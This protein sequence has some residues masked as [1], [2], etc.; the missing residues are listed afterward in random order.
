MKAEADRLTSEGQTVE[1]LSGY[2]VTA[3]FTAVGVDDPS[4]TIEVEIYGDKLYIGQ[5]N[6]T[7]FKSKGSLKCTSAIGSISK[8]VVEANYK[9]K[10]GAYDDITLKLSA[11]GN[12]WSKI[13]S[14]ALT[15]E[16]TGPYI[17]TA[18]IEDESINWFDIAVIDRTTTINN[19]EVTFTTD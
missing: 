1:T 10:T 18:V 6:E 12:T 11:N 17:S 13:N 8:V 15:Y 5:A 7:S 14:S 3:K 16:G 9:I 19:F 4:K 2:P